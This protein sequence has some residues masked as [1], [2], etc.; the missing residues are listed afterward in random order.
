MINLY[1]ADV[2]LSLGGTRIAN[3]SH[4]D[5]DSIGTTGSDTDSL[6]CHTDS[7]DVVD[8]DWYYHD[9]TIVEDRSAVNNTTT[10]VSEWLNQTVTKLYRTNTSTTGRQFYCMVNGTEW[11]VAVHVAIC[12]SYE[13][14]YRYTR[15]C[16]I[17]CYFSAII[18]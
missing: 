9:G 18:Q 11:I 17:T 6:L 12:K 10:T 14:W 8:V 16:I 2:S 15:H 5:I 3:N 1:T 7:V 4:V 13:Y